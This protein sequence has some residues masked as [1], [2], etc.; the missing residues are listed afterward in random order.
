[1]LNKNPPANQF[2]IEDIDQVKGAFRMKR[3]VFNDERGFFVEDLKESLDIPKFVQR[4]TS[5]SFGGV[6][7]GMH[8]QEGTPQG[9]LITC[10]YGNVLDVIFDIRKDSP[11][12]GQGIAEIL[13]FSH[14]NSIYAPPGC[15][16][17]FLAL[18]RFALVQYN[19]TAYY[20]PELDRGVKWN[21]PEIRDFF[22]EDIEPIISPKDQTLPSLSEYLAT[23]S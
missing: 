12:Y 10:Y 7:R 8:I 2:Q 19:C 13:D 17:G 15:L 6:L 16:H 21:S 20:D 23:L 22:P 9:K 11:T 18:S 1:M 5:F 3:K 4:N 14:C